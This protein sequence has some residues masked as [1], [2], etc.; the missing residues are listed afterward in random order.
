MDIP[1]GYQPWFVPIAVFPQGFS[2]FLLTLHGWLPTV[3]PRNVL[4][5]SRTRRRCGLRLRGR[6]RRR[7]L[8]GRRQLEQLLELQ[9]W[10]D[11]DNGDTN[12]AAKLMLSYIMVS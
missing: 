4:R 8:R 12:D 5:R 11:G 9:Q 3:A 2:H 6:V 1:N 10:F 7:R